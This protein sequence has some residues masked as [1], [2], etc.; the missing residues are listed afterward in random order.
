MKMYLTIIL[1]FTLCAGFSQE[2]KLNPEKSKIEWIGYGE[3]GDF[4]Q[5]G[6]IKAK[7]GNLS[8]NGDH[9]EKALVIINMKTINHEDKSLSDHLKKKDFFWSRKYPTAQ[10]T[11]TSLINN[12]ITGEL[13]IRG[14]SHTI[15]FP[16]EIIKNC[17]DIVVKGNMRIDR[18]KYDIKY[19]S[20]SFFQD[21][22]NYAIK[23]EF[24]LNFEIVF[25]QKN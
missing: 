4:K 23:N 2:F 6:D 25:E 9:I 14:I 18:T 8:L 20:S 19:N 3:I 24:D 11:F 1:I 7:E 16:V 22:G 17:N 10:L 5:N 21:L 13:T 12:Q 15:T